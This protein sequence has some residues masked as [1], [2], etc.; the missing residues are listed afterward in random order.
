M[1]VMMDIEIICKDHC[2]TFSHL[3]D[4]VTRIV[5]FCVLLVFK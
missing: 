4:Y 2:E 5:Y 3:L 1:I